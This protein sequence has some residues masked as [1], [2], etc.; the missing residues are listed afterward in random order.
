M[1]PNLYKVVYNTYRGDNYAGGFEDV[2]TYINSL[3]ELV[4]FRNKIVSVVPIK[5]NFQDYLSNSDITIVFE[6][7]DSEYN[8]NK[9]QDAWGQKMQL[10]KLEQDP[11]K[12]EISLAS[13]Y[14]QLGFKC[15]GNEN[16]MIKLIEENI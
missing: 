14:E 10:S 16:V 12:A 9:K 3:D 7:L 13:Y 8:E 11:V 4:K 6:R 5:A 1:K 2:T 15:S